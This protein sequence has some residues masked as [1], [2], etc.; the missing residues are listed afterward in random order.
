MSLIKSKQLDIDRYKSSVIDH[1]TDV[2][3]IDRVNRMF[4]GFSDDELRNEH[5]RLTILATF[6]NDLESD[7]NI[8]DFTRL[9][10]LHSEL[11]DRGYLNETDTKVDMLRLLASS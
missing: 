1:E 7:I 3:R 9:D 5:V 2:E 6:S 4:K 10:Y 11:I 8:E